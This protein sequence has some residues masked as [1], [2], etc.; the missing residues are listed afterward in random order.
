MITVYVN[1]GNDDD[2]MMPFSFTNMGLVYSVLKEDRTVMLYI[3]FSLAYFH[4][5]RNVGCAF[6]AR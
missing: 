6:L 1:V 3:P 4:V 2:L 5:F